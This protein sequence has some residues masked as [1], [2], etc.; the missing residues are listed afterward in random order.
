[1][2]K[3]QYQLRVSLNGSEPPVWRQI[4]LT[5]DLSLEDL[6]D[7]IQAA[8]GW[9]NQ[10]LYQFIIDEQIYGDRDLGSGETRHDASAVTLGELVKRPKTTLIYEY[11]LAD[12]WEH[13]V[14]V[15]KIKPIEASEVEIPQCIAGE[16]ACPPEGCGG[17][18]G[19]YEL[20]SVIKD[21]KHPAYSEFKEQYGDVDAKAFDIEA[22]NRRLR[23]LFDL[24]HAES[25][26]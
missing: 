21:E 24:N 22:S 7:I 17:I 5:G 14:L 16:N 13:E 10:E 19:Y 4:Q 20:L 11:D 1:M 25:P 9:Q 6:H 8:L 18:F 26:V 23:S 2:R 15:E 12:G 3:I